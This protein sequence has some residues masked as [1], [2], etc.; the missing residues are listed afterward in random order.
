MPTRLLR[1]CCVLGQA[2]AWRCNAVEH[3]AQTH[4]VIMSHCVTGSLLSVPVSNRDQ[5]STEVTCKNG[6]TD[7]TGIRQGK[8]QTGAVCHDMNTSLQELNHSWKLKHLPL[9]AELLC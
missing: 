2:A 1:A 9:V 6:V 4:K 7:T 8:H 5:A 3:V